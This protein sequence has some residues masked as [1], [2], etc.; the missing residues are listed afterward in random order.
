MTFADVTFAKVARSFGAALVIAATGPAHA[1]P[2]VTPPAETAPAAGAVQS[3][4]LPP[5]SAP[6]TTPAPVPPQE[7]QAPATSAAPP[8]SPS[9]PAP[10]APATPAPATPSPGTTAPA[11]PAP[12]TPAPAAPPQAAPGESVPPA[13]GAQHPDAVTGEMTVL[14]PMPVLTR[15]GTSSWAEGFD[16]IVLALDAITAQMGRLGLKRAGEAMIVYTSSDEAGFEFEA[17]IPYAGESTE[18]PGDDVKIGASYSGRVMKFHHSGSFADMDLT[19]EGIA[20][21]LDSRSAEAQDFYIERYR[22]DPT[23][24]EADALE[25]DIF[26]PLR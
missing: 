24:T 12:V 13:Q 18:R 25:V 7:P 22:T 10:T 8:A 23:T 26:V 6:A 15:T 9:A 3:A 19:Y 17:Q 5:V 2:A 11:T 20:N 1:Q 21:Y 16:N 4:P 14:N